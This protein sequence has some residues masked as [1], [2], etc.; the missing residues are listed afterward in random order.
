MPIETTT[1]T[2][3]EETVATKPAV[4]PAAKPEVKPEGKTEGKT[5]DKPTQKELIALAVDFLQ[6]HE[7]HD[8]ATAVHNAK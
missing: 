4:K 6:K 3:T 1:T 8:L 7:Q 5:A 2:K